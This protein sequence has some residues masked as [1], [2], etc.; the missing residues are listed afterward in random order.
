[1]KFLSIVL[2]QWWLCKASVFVEI[3][4]TNEVVQHDER[5]AEHN[6]ERPKV[7]LENRSSQKKQKST[8]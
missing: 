2:Y 4:E 8:V 7:K 3:P 5:K 1:M 6:C